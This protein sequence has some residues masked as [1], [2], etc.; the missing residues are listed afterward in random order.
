MEAINSMIDNEKF[1]KKDSSL[2]YL[3]NLCYSIEGSSPQD[4]VK[5]RKR[6][7]ESD[8]NN[9]FTLSWKKFFDVY[10]KIFP[11]IDIISYEMQ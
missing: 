2:Q 4:Q 11:K 7:A 10:C 5:S 9:S 6:K 1:S 8:K 3:R